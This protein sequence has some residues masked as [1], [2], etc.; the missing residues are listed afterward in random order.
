[1]GLGLLVF[2]LKFFIML[3]CKY[4]ENVDGSL[5]ANYNHDAN[6]RESQIQFDR[7]KDEN[8][9]PFNTE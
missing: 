9:R 6:R 1:M 5:Q 7:G 2:S 4:M 3:E 8:V